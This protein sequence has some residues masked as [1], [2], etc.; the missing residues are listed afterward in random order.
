MKNMMSSLSAFI[1]SNKRL[2]SF[3]SSILLILTSI[4]AI[5]SAFAESK[6]KLL[7]VYS[8]HCRMCHVFEDQVIADPEVK[9]ELSRFQYEKVNAR[10]SKVRVTVTP[11]IVIYNSKQEQVR[12]MVPPLDPDEFI[13]LLRKVK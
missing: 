2:L 3:A 4:F 1:S 5:H 9:R 11:T 7:Y 13:A 8:D 12:K 10:H 6:P